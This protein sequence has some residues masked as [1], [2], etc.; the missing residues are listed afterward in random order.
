M[1]TKRASG[2]GFAIR[3]FF[4]YFSKLFPPAGRV[5]IFKW[6]HSMKTMK[7]RTLS[8]LSIPCLLAILVPGSQAAETRLAE[9]TPQTQ[10]TGYH[11]VPAPENLQARENF[12]DQKFG[13]FLHWGLYSMLAQGEWYMNRGIDH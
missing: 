13:I 9:P 12:R 3:Q 5:P 8:L 6:N 7:K 10:D 1:P 11:Y 4:L 2:K